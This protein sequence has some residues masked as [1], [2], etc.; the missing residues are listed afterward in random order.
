M[1]QN[2]YNQRFPILSVD[3]NLCLRQQE[4]KDIEPF[5]AYYTDPCVSQHILASSPTTLKEA[6][7]EIQYCHDLFPTKRGIYWTL[8][9]KE[10]DMMIG[11]V[12]MYINNSHHRAE[13]CY[14]LAKHFWRQG[15][16]TR[17][18]SSVIK[19]AFTH[20]EIHRIEAVTLKVNIGST[21]ILEKLGFNYEGTM[22]NYRYYSGRPHDIEMFSLT[23]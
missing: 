4:T 13:I 18:L 2:F 8:A 11:A 16:M 7:V 1:I 14:D 9:R 22:K 15:I 21:R 23:P 19:F 3:E 20:M 12:G 6:G 17:A 5:F 10:D